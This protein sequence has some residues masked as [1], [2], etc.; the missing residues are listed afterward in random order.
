MGH[1]FL[2]EAYAFVSM[3]ENEGLV[4]T[5]ALKNDDKQSLQSETKP[6]RYFRSI[7]VLGNKTDFVWPLYTAYSLDICSWY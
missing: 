4:K 6:P 7:E 5:L 1:M 3:H 2:L